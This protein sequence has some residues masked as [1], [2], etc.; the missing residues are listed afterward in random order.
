MKSTLS[1][2]LITP[3]NFFGIGSLWGAARTKSVHGPH[4]SWLL[5]YVFPWR[6]A[7]IGSH[8][9]SAGLPSNLKPASKEMISDSVRNWSLILTHPTEWNKRMTSQNAQCSTWCRFW[10][11]K[12]YCKIEVLKQ[13]QPA[14]FG[15]VS[16]HGNTVCIHMYD[17]CKISIDS[18]VCHRLLSILWWIVQVCSLTIEYQ[19]FQYVPSIIIS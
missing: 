15:S 5:W 17:E 6:I 7:T 11:L 12:I 13:S 18:C 3:W 19:V 14:L 9:S 4:R 1:R 2:S 10:I 16:P 8:K